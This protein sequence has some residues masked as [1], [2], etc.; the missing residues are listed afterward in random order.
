[1]AHKVVFPGR[2]EERDLAAYYHAAD[3]FCLPSCEQSEAFG[4]VQLEAMACAKPIVNCDLGNGVNFVAPHGV[5]ALS[6]PARDPAALAGALSGLLADAGRRNALGAAGLD[7]V[8]GM[9]SV[10]RMVDEHVALYRELLD[11]RR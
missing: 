9:F 1:M 11:V 4:I 6:V 2:I 3:V 5:C 7:R 8:T 10:R